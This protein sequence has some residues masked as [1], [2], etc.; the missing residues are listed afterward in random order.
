M[1]KSASL[2]ITNI[3]CLPSDV[4]HTATRMNWGK[5]T[6]A[7]NRNSNKSVKLAV[8]LVAITIILVILLWLFQ[9]TMWAFLNFL[10]DRQ[11]V[12]AYLDQLGFIGP[13]VLM[14][15]IGVQIVIPSLPAEPQMIAGSYIYG[16]TA[17]FL[18][19]WGVSVVV[20]Q[21][22]FCLARYAG[23]PVVERL[24][25]AQLLDK[26]MRIT[27][28]KGAVFFLMNLNRGGRVTPIF[29][30]WKCCTCWIQKNSKN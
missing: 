6:A 13:L 28:E 2:L 29:F 25:A 21:A 15:L 9:D 11:A 26:W 3:I 10:R 16:F 19:I 5:K 18:M 17:G 30:C 8:T 27:S 22:V 7:V 24:I 14:G 20:S 4:W 23:R 12:S 1:H